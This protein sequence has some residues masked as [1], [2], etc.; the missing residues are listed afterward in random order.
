MPMQNGYFQMSQQQQ[1]QQMRASFSMPPSQAYMQS[2]AF[3]QQQHPGQ[4]HP[5]QHGQ[6]RWWGNN[7]NPSVSNGSGM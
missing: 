5:G 7:P 4:Q 1:Q 6:Q 3:N 2:M